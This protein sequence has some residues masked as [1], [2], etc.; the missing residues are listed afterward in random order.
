[1]YYT[2]MKLHIDPL[3]NS[4]KQVANPNIQVN[5]N[6]PHNLLWILQN[7]VRLGY[8]SKTEGAGDEDYDQ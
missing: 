6:A 7:S 8:L 1:M 2:C 3:Y 4:C 5:F